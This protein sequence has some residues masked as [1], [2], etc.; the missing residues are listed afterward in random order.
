MAPCGFLKP[1]KPGKIS[2]WGSLDCGR[3]KR[4]AD[5]TRIAG[6]IELIGSAP[7]A[8]RSRPAYVFEEV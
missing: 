7:D 8:S 1:G 3:G 2:A 5:A 6:T 4:A